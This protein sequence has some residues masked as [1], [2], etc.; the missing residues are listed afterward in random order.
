MDLFALGTNHTAALHLYRCPGE[1]YRNAARI[2][3]LCL[4]GALNKNRA[5]FDVRPARMSPIQLYG[6]GGRDLALKI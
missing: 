2:V 1:G 5:G 4:M 3:F 6:Y